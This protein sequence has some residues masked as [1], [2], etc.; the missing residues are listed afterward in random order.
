MSMLADLPPG[1]TGL[2]QL[3]ALIDRD[4]QPP[5]HETLHIRL[6]AVDEGRATVEAEPGDAHLNP[7]GIVQGGYVAAVLDTACGCAV[8]ASLPANT[9]FSTAELKVS[10]HRPVTDRAGLVRAEGQTLS[11]GRRAAFSEAKLY[12]Q[13][14]R[15]LASAT[16]TL[17]IL[18]IGRADG[19]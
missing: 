10:Y 14:G 17:V 5:I 18:P 13:R 7:A 12:D 11:V 8:H 9:G 2:E 19:G 16:S 15:L 3:R 6:V 1:L 4:R